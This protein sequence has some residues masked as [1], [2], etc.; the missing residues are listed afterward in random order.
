MASLST[1]ARDLKPAIELTGETASQDLP[2]ILRRIETAPNKEV[3]AVLA[4]AVFGTGIDISRLGLMAVMGQPKTTS[5]YIQSTGRIGRKIGGLVVTYL[6]AAR[7]RDLNHYENF[8]GY[9]RMIQNFVEPISAAPYSEQTLQTCLGAISV[10]ILRNARD[11][12]KTRVAQEWAKAD[13]PIRMKSR[14]NDPEVSSL[15][16][17]LKKKI[18]SALIPVQRKPLS[19]SGQTVENTITHWETVAINLDR[20]NENLVYLQWTMNK[21][22][23]TNV[24]LGTEQAERHGFQVVYRLVRTSMRETEGQSN[25]G[26]EI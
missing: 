10:A 17:V 8:V 7:V 18:S 1:G 12:E 6:R 2:P 4:T 25:F 14:R 9:H 26:D 19:S 21:P 16:S 20:A 5:S 3:D 13:Q 15:E 11:I 24:V 23:T 22:P